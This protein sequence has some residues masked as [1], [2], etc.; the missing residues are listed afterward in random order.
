MTIMSFL[1][2]G[3]RGSEKSTDMPII[4]SIGHILQGSVPRPMN[5]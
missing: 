5:R 2:M 4:D 3:N 1:Q